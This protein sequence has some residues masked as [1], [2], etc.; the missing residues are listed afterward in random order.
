MLFS[1][2][3]IMAFQLSIRAAASAALAVEIA[4]RLQL[5]YPIYA[6]IGAVI[7]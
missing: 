2:Q 6:L 1:I 3:Q 4:R 7:A 5:P